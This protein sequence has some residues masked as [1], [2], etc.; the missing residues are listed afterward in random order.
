ME[1]QKRDRTDDVRLGP[2]VYCGQHLAVHH[3]GWCTVGLEDKVGLGEFSGTDHEQGMAAA[4][5]CRR[6]GLKLYGRD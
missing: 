2:W 5:K 1:I 4:E 6:L 3:S